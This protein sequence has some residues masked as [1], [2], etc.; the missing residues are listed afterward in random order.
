[1]RTGDSITLIRNV[2]RVDK[3]VQDRGWSLAVARDLAVELNVSLATVYRYWEKCRI[4]TQRTIQVG[5]LEK[6]R[7]KQVSD[8]D[9]IRGKCEHAGDHDR[10]IRAIETQAKIIGTIAPVRVD[11]RI[12]GMVTHVPLTADLPRLLE[13]IVALGERRQAIEATSTAVLVEREEG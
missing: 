12:T 2:C 10:A 4:W 3:A 7:A 1:M 11:A 8:L 6:W 5:D 13:E 9:R